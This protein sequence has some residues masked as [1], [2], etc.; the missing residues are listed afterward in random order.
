VKLNLG[1][2]LSNLAEMAGLD[3]G[4]G[5]FL[6]DISITGSAGIARVSYGYDL[7]SIADA[8]SSGRPHTSLSTQYPSKTF[9]KF[10]PIFGVGINY[11]I[12]NHVMLKISADMQK[13]DGVYLDKGLTDTIT[14]KTAKVGLA[15]Y[16]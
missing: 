12:T 6:S 4:F 10:A 3:N 2:N 8:S 11:A 1:Y 7:P 9:N 16:F 13:F 14:I 15:Y 5:K